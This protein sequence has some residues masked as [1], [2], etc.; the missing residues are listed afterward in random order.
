MTVSPAA[1]RAHTVQEFSTLEVPNIHVADRITLLLDGDPAGR[2][3]TAEILPRLARHH[4]V[5]APE[6]PAGAEP[7]TINEQTLKAAIRPAAQ[8]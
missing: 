3:A 7:D 2:S 4:F 5:F 1:G 6:L 8:S